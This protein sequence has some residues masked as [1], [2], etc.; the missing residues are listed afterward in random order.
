MFASLFLYLSISLCLPASLYVSL[1]LSFSYYLLHSV[2]SHRFSSQHLF[3]FLSLSY[4]PFLSFCVPFTTLLSAYLF[5]LSLRL[6][7][8]LSHSLSLSP[9]FFLT[10]VFFHSLPTLYSSFSPLSLSNISFPYFPSTFLAL[11]FISSLL[12]LLSL[13]FAYSPPPL[14]VSQPQTL[15]YP[16]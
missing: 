9:S 7:L 15:R 5:L 11:N 2:F 16:T 10:L 6:S 14:T 12:L 13:S 4:L 3:P 1:S 8:S